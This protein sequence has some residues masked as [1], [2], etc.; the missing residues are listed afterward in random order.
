MTGVYKCKSP[1]LIELY[2]KAKEL[3]RKFDVINYQ[4]V[5]RNFN[6]RADE[7]SNIAVDNYLITQQ[8]KNKNNK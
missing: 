7:L 1:N 4:H 2:E 3:E 8:I 6:K 5:L